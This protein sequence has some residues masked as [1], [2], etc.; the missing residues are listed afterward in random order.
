M[1]G[2][3]AQ[4]AQVWQHALAPVPVLAG[5]Q[6]LGDV[7][8]VVLAAVAASLAQRLAVAQL[9]QLGRQSLRDGPDGQCLPKRDASAEVPV[10]R[11]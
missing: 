3:E 6:A 8:R 7:Q 2:R 4:Q 1:P 9:V 11:A 5:L 10:G